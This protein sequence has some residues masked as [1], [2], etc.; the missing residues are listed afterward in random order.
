MFNTYIHFYIIIIWWFLEPIN[1]L[2]H[3]HTYPAADLPSIVSY[4]IVYVYMISNLIFIQFKFAF[5]CY[6]LCCFDGNIFLNSVKVH[7][8][9]E[10][11]FFY[12]RSLWIISC[13][14][15]TQRDTLVWVSFYSAD[16]AATAHD[17]D[18]ADTFAFAFHESIKFIMM[19]QINSE[20][21]E[22]WAT[23]EKV[24][25]EREYLCTYNYAAEWIHKE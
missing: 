25:L 23:E 20:I 4:R 11:E 12:A 6:N 19:Q 21:K 17:A 14:T 22:S 7:V 9:F 10:F 15:H 16:A 13:W 5:L 8:I 2:D 24:I 1:S 3:H 18:A